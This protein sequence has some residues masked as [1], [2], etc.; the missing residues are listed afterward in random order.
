MRATLAAFLCSNCGCLT[1]LE[2]G[3]SIIA[4]A[5]LTLSVSGYY[6]NTIGIVRKGYMTTLQLQLMEPQTAVIGGIYAPQYSTKLEASVIQNDS[7]SANKATNPYRS[8]DIALSRIFPTQKEESR[9]QKVRKA[10]GVV[11]DCLSDEELDVY[12]T[13]F[14]NLINSWMDDYERQL[15]DNKT[16]KEILR[17]V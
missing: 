1:G 10:M 4:F 13:E 12:I 3:C 16:L 17:E 9:N 8:L 6:T 14:Q 2:A 5:L 7:R 15:F 11:V